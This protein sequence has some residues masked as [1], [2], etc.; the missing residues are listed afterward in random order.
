MASGYISYS[1]IYYSCIYFSMCVLI[2]HSD[3]D[4]Q[5]YLCNGA[6]GFLEPDVVKRLYTKMVLPL[7]APFQ[8]GLLATVA[9]AL[10]QK[11]RLVILLSAKYML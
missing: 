10:L 11:W 1:N 6:F 5:L 7:Y 2:S 3:F 9:V 4:V 8:V